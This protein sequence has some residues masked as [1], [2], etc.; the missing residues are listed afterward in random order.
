VAAS[1]AGKHVLIVDDDR[2]AGA[3]VEDRL[4]SADCSP[5]VRDRFNAVTTSEVLK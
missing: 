2:A 3:L 4:T 1:I 5:V